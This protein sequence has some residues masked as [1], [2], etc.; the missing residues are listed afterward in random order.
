[1]SRRL[2]VCSWSLRP[3]SPQE[4]VTR[5]RDCGLSAVQLALDPIRLGSWGARRDVQR[6]FDRAGIVILSG[7]MAMKGEDYSTLDRIKETGGVILDENWEA[8]RI[9]AEQNARIARAM[10]VRLVTFHAG[11]ISHDPSDPRRHLM[12]D[13]LRV[14]VDTFAQQGVATAFETG[15]ESA[16]T[17]LPALADLRRPEVGVNFDP[18]N[19]ILYG[20]GDPV[21]SV[22]RLARLIR[23][24][25]V[26]DAIPATSPGRW[27]S[28]TPAGK[29]A[30]PWHDFFATMARCNVR[31]DFLVER[32]AGDDR[33]RDIINAREL[34]QSIVPGIC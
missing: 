20:M 16:D 21:D 31:C 14:V 28:E 10:G 2:G 12:M 26:K 7:M 34:V 3:E 33:I 6:L 17:L 24:V 23:Q 22:R 18:A 25:H 29:G 9:A 19:M 5:V 15:Q 13:R 8:N 30:V 32:E 11:F 1:M 27:G 4:L